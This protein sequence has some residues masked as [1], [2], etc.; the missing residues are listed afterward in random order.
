MKGQK[1]IIITVVENGYAVSPVGY[2]N[3]FPREVFHT[4]DS[5]QQALVYLLCNPEEGIFDN[6]Y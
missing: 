2:A 3:K 1:E 6:R 5:L 4:L